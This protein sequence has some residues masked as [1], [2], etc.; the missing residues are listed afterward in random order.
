MRIRNSCIK[1]VS[2]S[3]FVFYAFIKFQITSII[4]F[5]NT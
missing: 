3:V 4:V 5:E 1:D 2:A